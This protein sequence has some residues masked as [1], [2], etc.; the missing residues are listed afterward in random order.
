MEKPSLFELVNR[1]LPCALFA[2]CHEHCREKGYAVREDMDILVVRAVREAVKGLDETT[3]NRVLD[4]AAV[5]AK[6]ILTAGNCND[7]N[8]MWVAL[9]HGMLLAANRGVRFPE[10]VLLIA[11]AAETELLE[12]AEEYGGHRT[13][14]KAAALMDNVAWARGW[15]KSP[16]EHT[17]LPR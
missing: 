5:E 11:T 4:R 13:I 6:D 7:A 10:N 12:H 8:Q 9:A 15:W 14:Q 17:K 3:R 2:L 1:A 16:L